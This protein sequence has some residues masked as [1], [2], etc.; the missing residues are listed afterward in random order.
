MGVDL[1]VEGNGHPGLYTLLWG[2]H[3]ACRCDMS[4]CAWPHRGLGFM[5]SH[6]WS[7]RK[8]CL[9]AGSAL[10][11]VPP[12]SLLTANSEPP[13]K[14]LNSKQFGEAFSSLGR[15]LVGCP[16]LPARDLTYGI[17]LGRRTLGDWPCA[18]SKSCNLFSSCLRVSDPAGA[19]HNRWGL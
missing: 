16:Q 7:S 3:N 10:F 19:S 15:P 14:K 1:V 8:S 4:F 6:R 18:L 9:V 2:V 11:E 5:E 17:R 12:T 13:T